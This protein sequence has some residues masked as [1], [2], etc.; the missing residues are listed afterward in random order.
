MLQRWCLET[1]DEVKPITSLQMFEDHVSWLVAQKSQL[2]S[3]VAIWHRARK[4]IANLAAKQAAE[5]IKVLLAATADQARLCRLEQGA[6]A[7]KVNTMIPCEA[8]LGLLCSMTLVAFQAEHA[9]QSTPQVHSPAATSTEP[10]TDIMG[11]VLAMPG[12]LGTKRLFEV[13]EFWM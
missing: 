6:V 9:D 4:H 8:L 13:T 11:N 3:V 1:F 12:T 2:S 5:E 10:E 7:Q